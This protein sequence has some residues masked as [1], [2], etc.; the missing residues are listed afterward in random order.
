MQ[1]N[2][3]ETLPKIMLAPSLGL[4]AAELGEMVGFSP[5][6]GGVDRGP[7]WMISGLRRGRFA[8]L[9]FPR[10]G[11]FPALRLDRLAAVWTKR[12]GEKS[13]EKR[14]HML[15][16]GGERSLVSLSL[17]LSLSTFFFC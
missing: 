14:G 1:N 16:A 6:S 15:H 17:S 10:P 3:A 11:Q 2:L 8:T 5:Q 9:P 12:L 7:G 13:N 4:M